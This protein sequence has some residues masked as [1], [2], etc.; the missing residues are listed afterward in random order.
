[1]KFMFRW[2]P[3]N[4]LD[5]SSFIKE[6]KITFFKLFEDFSIKIFFSQLDP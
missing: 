4:Y 1:L 5:T 3:P 2:D 6:P